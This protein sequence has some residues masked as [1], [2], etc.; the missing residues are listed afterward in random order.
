MSF[1]LMRIVRAEKHGVQVKDLP[2]IET[3]ACGAILFYLS[4]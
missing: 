1:E 4:C 3:F 2:L